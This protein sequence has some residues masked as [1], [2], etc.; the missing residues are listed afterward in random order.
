[1]VSLL[2]PDI[3]GLSARFFADITMLESKG[4]R[5]FTH[6][7]VLKDSRTVN[8]CLLSTKTAQTVLFWHGFGE[9]FRFW[10]GFGG[11]LADFGEPRG[12]V[13]IEVSRLWWIV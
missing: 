10:H 4:R 8:V 2:H 13:R 12:A 5:K 1:M 6:L 3:H 11:E 9:E 7:V